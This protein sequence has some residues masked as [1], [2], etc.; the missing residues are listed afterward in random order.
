MMVYYLDSSACVK[1]YFEERGSDWV[2]GL[3]EE[4]HFLSCSTLASSK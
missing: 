3:F 2:G 1:R 4:D